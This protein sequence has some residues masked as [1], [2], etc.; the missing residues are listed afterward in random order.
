MKQD[1]AK[2]NAQADQGV[3]EARE[4]IMPTRR[5]FIGRVAMAGGLIAAGGTSAVLA[6]C[7]SGNGNT[8][9]GTL[10][11]LPRTQAANIQSVASDIGVSNNN[12]QVTPQIQQ[13][14][15]VVQSALT[16]AQQSQL[17]AIASQIQSD[18]NGFVNSVLNPNTLT[19]TYSPQVQQIVDT[20]RAQLQG[21]PY[22]GGIVTVMNQGYPNARQ[23]GSNI[24][25]AFGSAVYN[26]FVDYSNAHQSCSTNIYTSCVATAL[27]DASASLN[28]LCTLVGEYSFAS[29]SVWAGMGA[30]ALIDL[31]TAIILIDLQLIATNFLSERS[32]CSSLC[33]TG[34]SGD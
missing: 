25:C 16:S 5:D 20:L 1:L 4:M 2:R 17:Q 34:S 13:L 19:V 22:N 9:G 32:S 7:G 6:G 27:F 24:S 29:G 15:Q 30:G 21:Q 8:S 10:T 31:I 3:V 18:P 14:A 11:T 33:L 26:R 12:G 23:D 28:A